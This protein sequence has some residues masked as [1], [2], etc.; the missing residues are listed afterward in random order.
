MGSNYLRVHPGPDLPSICPTG[1]CGGTVAEQ[2]G[3]RVLRSPLGPQR[4][5]RTDEPP[6]LQVYLSAPD[7]WSRAGRCRSLAVSLSLWVPV[8]RLHSLQLL[9][10]APGRPNVGL[11]MPQCHGLVRVAHCPLTG[12]TMLDPKV[13]LAQGAGWSWISWTRGPGRAQGSCPVLGLGECME[14]FQEERALV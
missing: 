7:P 13:M 9:R 3:G 8:A 6:Q 14:A 1:L 5:L 10:S 12:P 4:G 11:A 2:W